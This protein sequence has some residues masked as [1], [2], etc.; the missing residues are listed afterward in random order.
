M[1][2]RPGLIVAVLLV[3]FAVGVGLNAWVDG[4]AR[5]LAERSLP[6]LAPGQTPPPTAAPTLEPAELAGAFLA[7]ST[8][9][10]SYGTA[11]LRVVPVDD[12]ILPSGSVTAADPFL[13]DAQPF[14][15]RFDPGRY[16]VDLLVATFG[17]RDERVAAARVTKPGST[18]REWREARTATT[19]TASTSPGFFFGYGVDSGNGSFFSPEAGAAMLDA[20]F[21]DRMVAA[22]NRGTNSSW[23][24]A[25]L[26]VD[27]GTGANVIAF[28]SGFGDGA[29]A[30]YVGLDAAGR[31]V[32]FLTDFAILDRP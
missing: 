24:W 32:A 21:A 11:R 15:P 18:P 2:R 14:E 12:V 19:A 4:F 7:P 28:S 29:Y 16:P 1:S 23:D 27:P 25:D 22:L 20:G 9:A 13:P 6:T 26:V 5:S 3:L 8:R 30:T 31:P 10:T 17:A